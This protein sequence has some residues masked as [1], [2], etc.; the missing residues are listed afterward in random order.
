LELR[1]QAHMTTKLPAG[2]LRDQRLVQPPVRLLFA[3]MAA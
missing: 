3:E 1:R 2:R